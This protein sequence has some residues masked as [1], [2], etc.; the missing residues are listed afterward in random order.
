[1]AVEISTHTEDG[2]PSMSATIYH[3]PRNEA[4]GKE[5]YSLGHIDVVGGGARI[6]FNYGRNISG[7]LSFCRKHN[8]PVADRRPQSLK[9]QGVVA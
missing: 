2:S 8:I 7:L 3:Y 1:M 9:E 6:E 4:T 5:A